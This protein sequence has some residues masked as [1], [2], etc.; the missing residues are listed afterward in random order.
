MRMMKRVN[1][2]LNFGSFSLTSSYTTSRSARDSI[3]WL[4]QAD[5]SGVSG[6][7]TLRGIRYFLLGGTSLTDAGS[8]PLDRCGWLSGGIIDLPIDTANLVHD[9]VGNLDERDVRK[10]YPMRGP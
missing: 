6:T 5:L 1:W 9:T 4:H 8:L 3:K 10:L 2:R 7:R